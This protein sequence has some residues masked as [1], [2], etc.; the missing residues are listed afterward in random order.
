MSQ[1][2]KVEIGKLAFARR[3]ALLQLRKAIE[4]ERV[5]FRKAMAETQAEF[6]AE[7]AMLRTQLH[8]LRE[9]LTRS[10]K[11]DRA[12]LAR[13]R[14]QVAAWEAFEEKRAQQEQQPNAHLLQ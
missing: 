9:L 3:R 2:S 4:S 10:K 7:A 8:E 1:F 11:S 13:L 6:A 12:E 5:A 14:D